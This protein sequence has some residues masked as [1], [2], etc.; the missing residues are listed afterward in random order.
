MKL[1]AKNFF[2]IYKTTKSLKEKND[3]ALKPLNYT[4]YLAQNYLQRIFIFKKRETF[5][6][7]SFS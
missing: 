2:K 4:Y 1:L 5:L 7:S 3:I 6:I